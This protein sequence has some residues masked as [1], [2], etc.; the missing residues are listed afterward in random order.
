MA[1][2]TPEILIE[3]ITLLQNPDQV[4]IVRVSNIID[5][6]FKLG[7]QPTYEGYLDQAFAMPNPPAT[8]VQIEMAY[9]VM[10]VTQTKPE[11]WFLALVYLAEQ[12][13]M[14]DVKQSAL[15]A[16][17]HFDDRLAPITATL[18]QALASPDD[19]T[20][21]YASKL[22]GEL[23]KTNPELIAVLTQ[24]ESRETN[25]RVKG[26]IL[27]GLAHIPESTPYFLEILPRHIK[28]NDHNLRTNAV[29]SYDIFMKYRPEV[30]PINFENF[31]RS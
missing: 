2:T 8:A 10:E 22:L 28:S 19:M 23:A 14:V 17:T 25:L 13:Q 30:D 16:L 9:W 5:Y 31:L 24:H 21:F 29:W 1:M 20:R 18:M 27:E 26:S 6:H 11:R 15:R 12:A 7:Y 3:L 4:E